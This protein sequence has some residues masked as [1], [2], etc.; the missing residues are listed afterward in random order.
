MIVVDASV[1]VSVFVPQDVHHVESR[2]WFGDWVSDGQ[3]IVAPH[4]MLAEVAGAIARRLGEPELGH[5]AVTYL[6]AVP[7]LEIVDAIGPIAETS[8]AIADELRLRGADALYIAAAHHLGVPLVTWDRE[9]HE[10]AF[11]FVPVRCPSDL[12]STGG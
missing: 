8:I 9:Q 5:Q 11:Q 4:L 1:V 7:E 10:R 3:L 12:E 2:Q 6:R